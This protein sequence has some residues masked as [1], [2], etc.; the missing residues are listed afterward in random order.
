VIRRWLPIALWP[1]GIVFGLATELLQAQT[2]IRPLAWLAADLVGG[3][4][5]IAT[6]LIAWSSQ[7]A[8][9]I[10]RIATLVGFSWFIGTAGRAPDATV[11]YLANGFQGWFDPLLAWLIL[12]YPSGRLEGRAARLVVGAWLADL[13]VWTAA[14]LVLGRP[15][16]LYGCPTCPATI[17][18]YVSDHQLL[19]VVGPISLA[20]VTVLAVAVVGLTIRRIAEA[21]PAARRGLVP[22][23]LGGLLMAG[24]VGSSGVLRLVGLAGNP[25]ADTLTFA[26]LSILRMLVAVGILVGLLRYRM[27]RSAVADLVVELG[28][29]L[30]PTALRGALAGTLGDPSLELLRWDEPTGSYRSED[31]LAVGLPADGAGRAV[32]RLEHNGRRI[33]AIVHDPALRD[34]PGLV[35]AVGAAVRIAVDNERLAAEVARQLDEIRASRVRIVEAGDA[36]RRR[37]ERDLHDGAQ[38]RLIGLSLAIRR[39]RGHA[40]GSSGAEL[41]ATLAD[42]AN[43]LALAIEELRDLARGIHPAILTD[44]GLTAALESL[45]ARSPVPV[46]LDIAFDAERRFP[47]AVEAAAYFAASEALANA[48]KHAAAT[49]IRLAARA[50]DGRLRVEVADDGRGGADASRGS[51]LRGLAD[52]IAALGGRFSV[53]SPAAGGTLLVVELPDPAGSSAAPAG[54]S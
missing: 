30:A 11:A 24:S 35:A 28:S 18:R 39:A 50:G 6:G 44:A 3:W 37:I 20:F 51:G 48:A 4:L 16:D 54:P 52:R 27:A 17:D 21:T 46:H 41:D 33:G 53:T 49:S 32:T 34:D 31:G 42:A 38:Q 26:L 8:N 36:E 13:V 7:P 5:F 22:V 23:A 25:S 45:A 29:T 19:D 43:E 12:A 10:G 47:A 9:R 15:L 1:L 2:G 40:G 14:R